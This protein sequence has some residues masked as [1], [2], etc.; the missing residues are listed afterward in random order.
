MTEHLPANP[1]D[2]QKVDLICE[3]VAEGQTIR[4]IAVEL[5]CS[6]GHVIKIVTR[7][8]EFEKQYARARDVAA[9]LFEADIQDAAM[10]CSPHTAQADRV[11]IDAL[12]WIAARRSPKK[13]G[14]RVE[15]VHSGKLEVKARSVLDDFYG[16]DGQS[17]A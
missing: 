14:D 3:R 4:Q 17:D 6:P 12:K 16:D 8:P 2:Q 13:Y 9:D 1:E 5:G 7:H 10:L 11:K 15:Q